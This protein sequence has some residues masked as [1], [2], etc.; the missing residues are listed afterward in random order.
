[1]KR[2]LISIFIFLSIGQTA[3]SQGSLVHDLETF[4]EMVA[5]HSTNIRNYLEQFAVLED[6]LEAAKQ[7]VSGFQKAYSVADALFI[8]GDLL[9]DAYYETQGLITD[10]KYMN[11]TIRTLA[12]KGGIKLRDVNRLYRST[13]LTVKDVMRLYDSLKE[14]IAEGIN[15]DVKSRLDLIRD[16]LSAIRSKRAMQN[17]E[18]QNAVEQA[19]AALAASTAEILLDNMYGSV[20]TTIFLPLGVQVPVL[21][22]QEYLRKMRQQG[23]NN[24]VG[25]AD[26]STVAGAEKKTEDAVK[27]F[28]QNLESAANEQGALSP[29]GKFLLICVLVLSVIFGLPTFLKVTSGEHQSRNALWKWIVGTLTMIIVIYLFD[30]VI[31]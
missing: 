9:N 20:D 29:L 18:F 15:L 17:E 1:M 5:E 22:A 24:I 30:Y 16:I 25:G 6:Q 2:I 31:F 21:T 4:T 13:E 7:M 11:E 3:F 23:N 12:E 10:A 8:G 14:I 27:N 26:A 28:K 19:Q